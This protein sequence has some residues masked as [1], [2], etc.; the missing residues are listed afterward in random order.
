MR[1]A[2]VILIGRRGEGRLAERRRRGRGRNRSRTASNRNLDKLPGLRILDDLEAGR[3][4]GQVGKLSRVGIFHIA[5][6]T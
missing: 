2:L 4:L 5:A 6:T 1:D 3:C